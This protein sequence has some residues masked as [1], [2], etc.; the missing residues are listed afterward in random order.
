MGT[1]F[2]ARELRRVLADRLIFTDVSFSLR[3]GEILFVRGP[4]GIGKSVLLRSLACL[5]KPEGGVLKLNGRTPAELT[6]PS[7]RAQVTYVTQ[8]RVNFKGTPSEF[9]Y[10]V[11]QF[12]A[13]K[14]RPRRDL[15]TLVH[16]LGLEQA[17]LNQQ[18]V[19]L[20]GGQTQRVYLAIALAL[21]P[22]VLLLD[23]PTSA[24]DP[25]S[26]LRVEQVLV[27]SNTT[28]VWVTHDQ[29][30]P[31]RV[32]GYVLDLPTGT[33]AAI[34]PQLEDTIGEPLDDQHVLVIEEDG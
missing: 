29:D 19:E 26:T 20:S 16:Q 18:W 4:S 14:A 9:Y 1:T 12:G 2:E 13:Q 10:Q 25:A 27:E 28:L 8:S 17:V 21:Q 3:Q 23:E 5:D 34:A 33:V 24:C 31:L 7:W 6:Y 15:P 30:Q 22:A 32:G 11:Q